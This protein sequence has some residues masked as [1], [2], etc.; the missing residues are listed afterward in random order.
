MRVSEVNRN[1]I[2]TAGT[3]VNDRVRKLLLILTATMILI[4]LALILMFLNINTQYDSILKNADIAAGFNKEFKV[5]IDS[6]MYNHVIM[7][8][9]DDSETMLPTD[10]LDE[11]IGVLK[12][13]EQTTVLKDN[14]WRVHSMLDMCAN[15]RKYMTE[16]AREPSYDRRMELLDR[17]IRG[18]TGLTVLIE[19]YMHDYIDDEVREMARLQDTINMRTRLVLI[20]VVAGIALLVAL[21]LAGS[22]RVTR[23]I[24]TPLEALSRKA[25]DFGNG[26]FHSEPVPTDIR[27]LATLDRGF[28]DMA[29]RINALME[30]QMEDQ[31]YLHRAE[32]ELLQAQ[33]NPH[34]L[35]N[36]L[37][38]IAILA[39][40]H[41]EEDVVD[42]VTSLSSFF[43]NSLSKGKDLITLETEKKQVTSYLE[44]QSVRYS[45]KLRY[46]IDIPEELLH[47]IV[48]KLILQPLVENALYH[49]I[50]N[51]RGMGTI[52]IAAETDGKDLLLR[53]KDSGAGMSAEQLEALKAGIY[54][55]RHTGLGLLNVH[56]RIRLYCG[57]P[58]GL[59]FESSPGEGT[60]V[61]VR[62][63]MNLKT[64]E[65][66]PEVNGNA[67]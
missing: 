61:T 32:L 55:E 45:D 30:K 36:T 62:L 57:E 14:V 23:K 64:E 4:L 60:T 24:T 16:I 26:E 38:S 21:V 8:R 18:E 15:L 28:D 63:A 7:P 6:A 67:E 25:E 9:S 31:K 1:A 41:R 50:K 44:I 66:I 47:I 19:Q 29:A 35:Y 65:E 17:N 20:G 52:S 53:V 5:N 59:D 49:G 43:R 39:E 27:E 22:V 33:I 3:T 11:A 54:E 40:N 48:P 12:E 37:D 58:Y 56:K 2:I 51:R 42:M 10:E 13:L 46:E 34:F